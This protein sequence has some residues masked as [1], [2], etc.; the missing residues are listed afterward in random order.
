MAPDVLLRLPLPWEA[1]FLA[2]EAFLGCRR[3]K[4]AR[5]SPLPD[6]CIGAHAAIEG[7]Q[8]LTR[9]ARRCRTYGPKLALICPA[10]EHSARKDWERY[11]VA[12]GG[13]RKWPV[14]R[15]TVAP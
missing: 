13:A 8:L 3:A 4:G 14:F 11:A 10:A 2:D 15:Y 7:M 5:T 6:F 9:D 1:R 12:S